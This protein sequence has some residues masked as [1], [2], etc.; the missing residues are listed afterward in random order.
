MAFADCGEIPVLLVTPLL[1]LFTVFVDLGF[2]ELATVFSYQ[3]PVVERSHHESLT[4]TVSVH[5]LM[6]GLHQA[7][8]Q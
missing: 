3:V 7:S 2:V 6:P 4:Y 8:L 5:F 1:L